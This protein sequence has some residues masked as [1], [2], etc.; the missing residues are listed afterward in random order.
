MT[1]RTL[2]SVKEFESAKDYWLTGLK[3][4]P[5]E[6]RLVPDHLDAGDF[7]ANYE[8]KYLSQELSGALIRMSEG[9]DLSL[10]IIVLS[11]LKILLH[12]MSR[13]EDIVVAA[14]VKGDTAAQSNR[15]V[16]FRTYISPERSFREIWAQVKEAVVE[17]YKNQHYPLANILELLNVGNVHSVFK[18]IAVS[19][20]LHEWEWIQTALDDHQSDLVFWFKKNEARLML[21]VFYNSGKF[22]R[23]TAHSLIS[24]FQ[25]VLRQIVE[26]GDVCL[27]D[28][29]IIPDD[30]RRKVLIDFNN[31]KKKG[32]EL[33]LVQEMFQDQVISRA[34]ERAVLVK[35][36]QLTYRKLNKLVNLAAWDLRDHGIG[37]DC[38]VGLM[39]NM[40]LEL[41]VGILAIIKAGGAYVPIDMGLP[42]GRK[43]MILRDCAPRVILCDSENREAGRR[44]AG[45]IGCAVIPVHSENQDFARFSDPEVKNRLDDMLYVAYTVGTTGAPQGVVVEQR[46]LVNYICWRL[47]SNHFPRRNV[48]LQLLSFAGGGFGANFF[49]ALLSGGILVMT[50]QDQKQEPRDLARLIR[51]RKVTHM[52][53][54]P[55]IFHSLLQD[56]PIT[57]LESL[58]VVTLAGGACSEELVSSCRC[59]LPRLTLINEY[60]LRE[61]SVAAAAKVNVRENYPYIVGKPVSHCR[62]YI[63]DTSGNLVAVGVPGEICVSGIG[64]ARGYLNQP[65]RTAE[66]FVVNPFVEDT[67][68]Y[69]TGDL[70]RWNASG[71]IELLG[72]VDGSV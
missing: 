64:L 43:R 41:A 21:R 6:I 69:K 27:R 7:N 38:P 44:L 28:I 57:E 54:S 62:V 8:K 31:C 14:P 23:R 15:L 29:Q 20:Q 19:E 65:L 30:E 33:R 34:D 26:D 37:P 12:K 40:S 5:Q 4:M 39:V 18:V 42:L 63:L 50:F 51:D 16:L 70:G 45:D 68:M 61:I 11:V 48:T 52:S 17:G 2:S 55:G 71:E 58:K 35:D 3:G 60:G 59:A 67:F 47:T 72:R 22:K 53:L 56:A 13:Q 32:G 66:C 25:V 1:R 36:Q 10:Y 49:T 46:G 9:N 24:M